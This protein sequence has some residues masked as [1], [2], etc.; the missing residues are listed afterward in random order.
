MTTA[1]L[2]SGDIVYD[3]GLIDNLPNSDMAAYRRSM[4]LLADLDVSVVHPG[5][6]HSFDRP[7]LRQVAE[8][9]L[10]GKAQGCNLPRNFLDR[11]H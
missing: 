3:G 8:T 9:Y 6:G 1:T 4:Q 5:H 11:L 2:Y 10:R 7:R